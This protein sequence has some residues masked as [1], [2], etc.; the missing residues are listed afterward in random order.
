MSLANFL[1]VLLSVVMSTFAQLLLKAGANRIRDHVVIRTDTESIFTQ[2]FTYFN[3]Y[4]FIGLV[5]YVVSAATWIWVLTR[6][7]VSIA[8]PFISLGFIMTLVC[9]VAIFGESLSIGKVIGTSLIILGCV[10]VAKS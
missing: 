9:G 2:L 3:I 7:D 5:I 4:I 1:I 10:F 6:V 8:Y